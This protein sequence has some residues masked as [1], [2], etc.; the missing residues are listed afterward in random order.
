MRNLAIRMNPTID[1]K[2]DTRVMISDAITNFYRDLA[3]AMSICTGLKSLTLEVIHEA[4]LALDKDGEL[5]L[6]RGTVDLF[7]LAEL[8]HV[9]KWGWRYAGGGRLAKGEDL[10]LTFLGQGQM[11]CFFPK[12]WKEN[13]WEYL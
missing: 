6:H 2:F 7:S 11:Y 9:L 3:K 1:P 13:P 10:E 4:L 8:E 5:S 12:G